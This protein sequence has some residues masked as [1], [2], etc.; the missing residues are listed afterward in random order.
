ME[1]NND[2]SRL[3][4]IVEGRVQGVGFRWWVRREAIELGLR[5]T[6]RNLPDGSVEVHATGPPELLDIL[7]AALRSG[8]PGACVERVRIAPS[9]GELPR[10]FRVIG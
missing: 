1:P 10:D 7:D 9:S 3:R 6:I 8:P 4:V 2:Q 5:G